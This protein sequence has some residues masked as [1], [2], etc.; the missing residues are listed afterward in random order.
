MPYDPQDVEQL[1]RMVR[2]R[3][4]AFGWDADKAV[5]VIAEA[6]EQAD[7]L[8]HSFN[9]TQGVVIEC[10]ESTYEECEETWDKDDDDP[11]QCAIG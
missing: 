10:L 4:R 9:Y 6:V 7:S 3:C 11:P 5:V 2:R 1:M 8:G